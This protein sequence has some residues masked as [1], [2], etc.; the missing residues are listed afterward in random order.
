[1][2]NNPSISGLSGISCLS[3]NVCTVVGGS[4]IYDTTDGGNGWV[5]QTVP[6]S[7]GSLVGVDCAGTVNCVA[8]GLGTNLGGA[9]VT[10]SA[11]PTVASTNL[12]QG[13]IGVRYS[14]WLQATGGLAPYTWN[15]VG[16]SLPPDCDS[17]PTAS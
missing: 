8:S 2:L 3:Q 7:V 13:T 17:L 4:S 9:I 1:M 14:A 5:T 6:A 10:L 16:G 12:T 15:L 11:P